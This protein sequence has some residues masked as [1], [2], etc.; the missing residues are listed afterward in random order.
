MTFVEK[1]VSFSLL[2]KEVVCLNPILENVFGKAEHDTLLAQAKFDGDA[3]IQNMLNP[4]KF[5]ADLLQ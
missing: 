2:H 4:N 1:K 3:A 5:I